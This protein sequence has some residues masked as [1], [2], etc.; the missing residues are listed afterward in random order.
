MTAPRTPSEILE[1]RAR[2]LARPA[3]SETAAAF[4]VEMLAFSVGRE[5]YAV[6]SRF[7]FAVVQLADLVP[8]PGARAPVVGLTRW[9]GDV[10]TVLDLRRVVGGAPGALDDLGRVIAMGVTS[11]EFGVLADILDGL[12]VVDPSSLH[13]LR[14]ERNVEIPGLIRGV[15]SD[16][17]HVLD[18]AVLI[19]HQTSGAQQLSPVVPPSTSGS[20]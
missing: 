11:P 20:Q 1:D 5:R 14:S 2:R 13:P 8:L 6:E 7:V 3:A 9:R 10:L 18:A 4:G 17:V 16:A 19:A 12:L 15:T